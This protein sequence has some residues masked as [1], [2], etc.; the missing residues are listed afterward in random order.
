MRDKKDAVHSMKGQAGSSILLKLSEGNSG[1]HIFGSHTLDLLFIQSFIR[2]IT[3][4][5]GKI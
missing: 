5:A 1:V 4:F 2:D 3:F